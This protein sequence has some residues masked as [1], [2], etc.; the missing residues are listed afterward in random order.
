MTAEFVTEVRTTQA[1]TQS[2]SEK[3][4]RIEKRLDA[5]APSFAALLAL[6][7]F[8]GVIAADIRKPLWYDEIFARYVSHLE[9]PG[10][11][12]QALRDS[13]DNQPFPFYVLTHY[14]QTLFGDNSFT[15]AK[16]RLWYVVNDVRTAGS[17]PDTDDLALA[18]L[19]RIEPLPVLGTSEFLPLHR[20]FLVAQARP[21]WLIPWLLNQG[22]TV[23]FVKD[24]YPL[25][26]VEV[27]FK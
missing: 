1:T 20:T 25:I 11:I 23:K 19:A 14:S 8:A 22:A 26:T 18:R 21:V 15:R 24:D 27:P 7:Y 4:A 12:W 6:I 3:I 9:S 16:S 5:T 10:A 17:G 13:V 2:R